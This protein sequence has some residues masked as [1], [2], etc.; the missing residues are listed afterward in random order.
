MGYGDSSFMRHYQNAFSCIVII[1]LWYLHSWI[2]FKDLGT[3]DAVFGFESIVKFSGQIAFHASGQPLVF[4]VGKKSAAA[5]NRN[6][7][8][9]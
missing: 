3:S 4:E 2:V 9:V 5:I 1:D 6:L 8:Y 7:H